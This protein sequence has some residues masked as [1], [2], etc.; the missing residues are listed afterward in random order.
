M[1]RR[2]RGI[3]RPMIEIIIAEFNTQPATTFSAGRTLRSGS[4][5]TSPEPDR[6]SAQHVRS[7]ETPMQHRTSDVKNDQS[8]EQNGDRYVRGPGSS[9]EQRVDEQRR[10]REEAGGSDLEP[11]AARRT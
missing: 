9:G 7:E 3:Y 8:A 4:T 11:S 2:Y 6:R 10:S 5:G 1:A